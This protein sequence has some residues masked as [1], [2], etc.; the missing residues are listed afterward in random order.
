MLSIDKE[1]LNEEAKLDGC[2]VLKSSLP[3]QSA[4]AETIQGFIICGVGISQ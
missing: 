2:Y 4:T 1:T 3:E